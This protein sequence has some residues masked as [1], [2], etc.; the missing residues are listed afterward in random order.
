M[1]DFFMSG[2]KEKKLNLPQSLLLL[3]LIIVSVAVCIRLKTGG[4]MIGLFASWI[5][6]YLFCK[7][8]GISYTNIVAGAYDAIRRQ[9]VGTTIRMA[10]YAPAPGC[11]VAPLPPSFPGA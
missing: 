10:S 5:F 7:I 3:L 1:G 2:T 9:S 4:P 8:F 6:I 11:R